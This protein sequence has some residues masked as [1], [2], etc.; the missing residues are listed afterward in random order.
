MTVMMIQQVGS[1]P[2]NKCT[3]Y[4]SR[5][6]RPPQQ[7]QQGSLFTRH[8]IVAINV[9]LEP[10]RYAFSRESGPYNP[11]AEGGLAAL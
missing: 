9:N 2:A 6:L 3:S 5:L 11:G 8:E 4:R 7:Q 1:S 10:S